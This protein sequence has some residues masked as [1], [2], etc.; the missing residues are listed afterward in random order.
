MRRRPQTPLWSLGCALATEVLD[1][2]V[3]KAKSQQHHCM[4]DSRC[5]VYLGWV[6]DHTQEHDARAHMHHAVCFCSSYLLRSACKMVN[7]ALT[8]YC[9]VHQQDHITE[10]QTKTQQLASSAFCLGISGFWTPVHLLSLQYSAGAPHQHFPLS[11]L[12][13]LLLAFDCCVCPLQ[14]CKSE[15]LV[16]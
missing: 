4:Y 9:L 10:R 7:G 8:L 2:A 14:A 12:W 16:D 3:G 15:S 11:T 1:E 13:R 6:P 5:K